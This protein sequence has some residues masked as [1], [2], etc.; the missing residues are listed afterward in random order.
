MSGRSSHRGDNVPTENLVLKSGY[1]GSH[2]W[3][4]GRLTGLITL[5]PQTRRDPAS[6]ASQQRSQAHSRAQ[7]RHG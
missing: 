3:D 2:L 5:F 1:K 7:I 4:R 6:Q